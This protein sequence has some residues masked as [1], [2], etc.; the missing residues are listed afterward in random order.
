MTYQRIISTN[1]LSNT[2]NDLLKEIKY[3]RLFVLT[4][5]HTA[6]LCYPLIAQNTYGALHIT[7]PAGDENKHINTLCHVWKELSY[8]NATRHSLIINLGG[9]MV[10]DL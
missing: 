3:D 9:G 6:K 5:E 1:H 10:T 2:L 8:N 7:I 4:D